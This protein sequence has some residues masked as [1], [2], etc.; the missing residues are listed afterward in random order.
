[1]NEDGDQAD[2]RGDR[3]GPLQDGEKVEFEVHGVGKMSLNV[4]DPLK[5][6]WEKGI[7]MGADSTHPDAVQRN[8][9]R[10]PMPTSVTRPLLRVKPL[11][12]F[13]HEFAAT[14]DTAPRTPEMT[15][16]TPVH[17]CSHGGRWRQ[18]YR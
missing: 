1:M 7:Y 18:P 15:S 10:S 5:R 9:P 13:I 14:T 4:V 12:W 8:R 17:Q 16:G 3:L 2:Q 6:S 11:G